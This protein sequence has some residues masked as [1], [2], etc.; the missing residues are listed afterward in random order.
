MP[1]KSMGFTSF[2]HP[3]ISGVISPYLSLF[4]FFS[5]PILAL[6]LNQEMKGSDATPKSSERRASASAVNQAPDAGL[7]AWDAGSFDFK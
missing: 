2:F 7:V 5:G 4:F 3:K 1:R 6:F